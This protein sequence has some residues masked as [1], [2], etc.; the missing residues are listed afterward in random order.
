MKVEKGIALT[1]SIYSAHTDTHAIPL[2]PHTH[3][4]ARTWHAWTPD[5]VW[6]S[7][8]RL[9]VPAARRQFPTQR[10]FTSKKLGWSSL[11]GV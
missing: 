11:C 5:L 4:R 1:L 6:F 2:H 3:T 7:C 10:G 9:P 8:W